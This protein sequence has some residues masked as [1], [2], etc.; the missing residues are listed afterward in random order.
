MSGATAFNGNLFE[1]EHLMIEDDVGSFDIR[2]RR[3]FGAYL[4]QFTANE[5]V[6][7]HAKNRQAMT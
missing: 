4:K 6:Q 5:G 7:H 2:A 1:A 3:H